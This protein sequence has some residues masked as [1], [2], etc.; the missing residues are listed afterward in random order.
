[1]EHD[2]TAL[3]RIV[4]GDT[5]VYVRTVAHSPERVWRA[6][7]DEAEL[8][9]WMRY[10]VRFLPEVGARVDFFSGELIGQVFI[11]DAPRTLAFS[12]FDADKPELAARVPVDW[13][14]RWDLEPVAGGCQVTFT[15]RWL[16]G[17]VMWGVG[18]GWHDFLDGLTPY[19]DGRPVPAQQEDAWQGMLGTYRSYIS[20]ELRAWATAAAGDARDALEQNDEERLAEDVRRLELAA[21]LLADIA[22]QNANEPSFA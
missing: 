6:I 10:P 11:V 18:A 21:N 8:S 19:L 15:H 5:L 20:D 2:N 7:S 22:R 17:H 3:G 9:A 12:L 16:L 13:T 4:D 14:V 1:M